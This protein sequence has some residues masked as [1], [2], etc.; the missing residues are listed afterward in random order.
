[1]TVATHPGHRARVEAAGVGF[2][3]LRPDFGPDLH[4]RMFDPRHGTEFTF[5]DLVTP[6]IRDSYADLSR[7]AAGADLLLASPAAFAVP[8]VAERMSVPWVSLALAPCG[9]VSAH[10][11]PW[12]PSLGPLWPLRPFGPVY[13]RTVRTVVALKTRAWAAPIHALRREL[14]LPPGPNPFAR[15]LCSPTLSLAM[16]SP[17]LGRPQP[18]WPAS[19]RITGFAFHDRE[20]PGRELPPALAAFLDAGP[21][22]IIV[23]LGSGAASTTAAGPILAATLAAARA[24]GRRALL[25][26]GDDPRARAT[27]PHPLPNGA[28]AFAYAPLARVFP[29]A[30]AIVHQGGI[31]TLGQALRAGRPMLVVPFAFD[32]HDNALRASRLGVA[33]VLPA[34]RHDAR[35]ATEALA[36]LLAASTVAARAETVAQAVRTEDG[37][38]AAANAIEEVLGLGPVR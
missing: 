22:P 20:D 26:T 32:Q 38:T 2:A 11:P 10:D 23:T 9:F 33:R 24:L 35:S 8:L 37:A 34:G 6:A 19:A 31:G 18:D 3:P 21:A 28:A 12:F 17:V 30:A 7:A 29:H 1:M 27:L 13:G 25:L 36:A 5:R 15:G 4:D 16:F 14:G